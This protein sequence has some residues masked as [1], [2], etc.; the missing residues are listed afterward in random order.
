VRPERHA[1]CRWAGFTP[2]SGNDCRI[3]CC[4]IE[5]DEPLLHE[6][7]DFRSIAEVEPALVVVG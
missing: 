3:A 7:R 4:A 5:A 1:L 6:D 2:R